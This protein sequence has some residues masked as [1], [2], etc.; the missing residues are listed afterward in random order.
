LREPGIAQHR[1]DD[2]HRQRVLIRDE[3]PT[4]DVGG[5]LVVADHIRYSLFAIRS[6]RHLADAGELVCPRQ[7]GDDG[8][9]GTPL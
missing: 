6:C 8:G 9:E 5:N 4:A 3:A 1:G 2:L 7:G